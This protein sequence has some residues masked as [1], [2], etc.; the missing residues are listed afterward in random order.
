MIGEKKPS[1][2]RR[3]LID[4]SSVPREQK[5]RSSGEKLRISATVR[6]VFQTE[7]GVAVTVYG[8]PYHDLQRLLARLGAN[9]RV[10][11]VSW[12]QLEAHS[13]A[14]TD[15]GAIDRLLDDGFELAEWVKNA[16][17]AG[18]NIVAMA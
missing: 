14:I 7:N 18:F 5:G 1:R 17:R 9:N 12:V 11:E 3:C 16:R 6:L 10:R 13:T 15:R 4:K 8:L 2:N